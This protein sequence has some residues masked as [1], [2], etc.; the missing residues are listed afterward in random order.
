MTFLFLNSDQIGIHEPELGRKLLGAFLDK[1][2]AS[3]VRID[4]VAC[5]NSA[6]RLTTEDGPAL[7]SLRALASR[8]AIITTCGT[9]LEHYQRKE[10]L[11]LG[12]VGGMQQTVELFASAD[13]IISPC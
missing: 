12:A 6:I 3:E 13:R 7:G 10:Q 8:G 1:L 4:F 2:V 11:L 9:C 5:L